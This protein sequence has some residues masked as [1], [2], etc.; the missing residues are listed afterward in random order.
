MAPNYAFRPMTK[1]DLPLIRRWLGAAH[2]RE[3]WGD[4]DE[5]LAL[6]SDDLGDPAM[7]QFI[8]LAGE[9]ALGYLQCY[10]LT[11]WNTRLWAATGGYAWDRPV[12]WRECND[13]ARP[14]LGVHPPIR[15]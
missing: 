8:A 4:P 6:V 15:R 11:A 3:W 14:W 7:D 10:R 5:Q 2:V 13:R 9:Q 1:A 12:H